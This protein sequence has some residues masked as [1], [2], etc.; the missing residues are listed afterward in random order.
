[1]RYDAKQNQVDCQYHEDHDRSVSQV[2][3][4]GLESENTIEPDQI[5]DLTRS[6]PTL[7]LVERMKQI[8]KVLT[9]CQPKPREQVP[10]IAVKAKAGDVRKQGHRG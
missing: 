2:V 7:R 3:S 4:S 10:V 6:H 5:P 1:L 9:W 8:N